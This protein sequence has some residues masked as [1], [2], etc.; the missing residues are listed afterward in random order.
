MSSAPAD[1]RAFDRLCEYRYGDVA[2][3]VVRARVGES[4]LL[5]PLAS[6]VALWAIAS[7][8]AFRFLGLWSWYEFPRWAREA[9]E[10]YLQWSIILT[11]VLPVAALLLRPTLGRLNWGARRVDALLAAA[12]LASSIPAVLSAYDLQLLTLALAWMC[13]LAARQRTAMPVEVFVGRWFGLL[14]VHSD[15]FESDIR[16]DRRMQGRRLL[17][18]ASI[19]WASVA[20]AQLLLHAF[21]DHYQL[22]WFSLPFASEMD[23]YEFFYDHRISYTFVLALATVCALDRWRD[24]AAG[25]ES[26]DRLF[27]LATIAIS[28]PTYQVSLEPLGTI[29]GTFVLVQIAAIAIRGGTLGGSNLR[30]PFGGQSQ[31]NHPEIEDLP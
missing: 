7:I 26:M 23:V 8:C 18:S 1:L 12:V 25:R 14:N 19:V 31:S 28:L 17:L 29:A 5:L 13:D 24:T 21:R 30:L 11:S 6:L 10:P 9:P 16:P 27:A 22:Y 3:A 2:P 4:G 20:L 15:R